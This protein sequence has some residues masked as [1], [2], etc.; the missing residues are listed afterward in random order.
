MF[1]SLMMFA[2]GVVASLPSS[3]SASCVFCSAGSR[4]LKLA[5]MRPDSEMSRLSTAIPAGAANVWMIG[6][7]EYVASAGAGDVLVLADH[8]DVRGAGWDRGRESR[9]LAVG[10]HP[11]QLQRP[12]AGRAEDA[13]SA[14]RARQT[15]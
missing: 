15:G 8:P 11:R 14:G 6:K 10:S 12:A 2:S 4:S 7:N 3:A 13:R 5:R 1:G 9:H